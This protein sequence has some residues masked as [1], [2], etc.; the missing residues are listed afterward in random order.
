MMLTYDSDIQIS[1]LGIWS[2]NHEGRRS[3]DLDETQTL[4]ACTDLTGVEYV[5]GYWTTCEINNNNKQL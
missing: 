4:A 1:K 3:V 5:K 2:T